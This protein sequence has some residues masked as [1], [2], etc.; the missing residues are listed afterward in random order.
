MELLGMTLR[1]GKGW[2]VGDGIVLEQPALAALRWQHAAAAAPGAAG[3]AARRQG[4][5]ATPRTHQ[6][7]SACGSDSATRGAEG[8][9]P[10]ELPLFM[11]TPPL[12]PE[13][14]PGGKEPSSCAR[15]AS[16]SESSSPDP[17]GSC[18]G[19][20]APR[21]AAG[22]AP[23][24]PALGSGADAE[25]PNGGT[26]GGP[27]ARRAA[28]GL[29]VTLLLSCP[30]V[31]TPALSAGLWGVDMLL[32]VLMVV[33]EGPPAELNG[34]GGCQSARAS[35]PLASLSPS[36]F[37]VREGA[38]VRGLPSPRRRSSAQPAVAAQ[39]AAANAPTAMPAMAAEERPPLSGAAA[40]LPAAVGSSALQ[41]SVAVGLAT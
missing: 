32:R 21:P 37:A 18:G 10:S 33:A 39:A 26:L 24:L 12:L 28:K 31:R 15:N 3:W 4:A 6:S 14:M 7:C 40:A 30:A 34:L 29:A 22:G 17:G 36:S 23:P 27:R 13:L 19:G 25:L 35:A 20:A 5:P 41:Y 9:E 2:A 38:T 8:V 11:P 16:S 1:Q